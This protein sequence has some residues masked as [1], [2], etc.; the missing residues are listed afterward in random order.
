M[1]PAFQHH[2]KITHI[3]ENVGACLSEEY[4]PAVRANHVHAKLPDIGI[5]Q[6]R[7]DPDATIKWPAQSSMHSAQ[8]RS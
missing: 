4:G 6:L 1:L 7:P 5:Q 8:G 2:M 3:N